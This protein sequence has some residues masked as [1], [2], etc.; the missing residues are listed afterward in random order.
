MPGAQLA[1]Q[2]QAVHSRHEDVYK[3]N[4]IRVGFQAYE[5]FFTAGCTVGFPA[6]ARKHSLNKFMDGRII[7]HD[8]EPV[9]LLRGWH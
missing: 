3:Q 1:K 2:L 6:A 8:Q 9:W 7:I 4:V 5:R